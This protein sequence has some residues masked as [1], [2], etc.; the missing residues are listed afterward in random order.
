[1]TPEYEEAVRKFELADS[2]LSGQPGDVSQW[3]RYYSA[4]VDYFSA[5]DADLHNLD[6]E[7]IWTRALSAD[8]QTLIVTMTRADAVRTLS[9][10]LRDSQLTEESTRRNVVLQSVSD[11]SVTAEPITLLNSFL[12][13]DL[14][15]LKDLNIPPEAY[16]YGYYRIDSGEIQTYAVDPQASVTIYDISQ[17]YSQREDR[18]HTFETYRDFVAAVQDNGNLLIQPYTLTLRNG[19]VIKIEEKFYN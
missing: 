3:P 4:F 16:P 19:V 11:A 18:K 12:E 17:A 6:A 13:E 5:M 14:Q 15:I 7:T 2:K 9:Y 10:S 8:G 1:M